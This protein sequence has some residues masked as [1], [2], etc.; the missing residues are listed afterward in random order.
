LLIIG[1]K[2]TV[3]NTMKQT[4]FERAAID[5]L[6]KRWYDAFDEMYSKIADTCATKLFIENETNTKGTSIIRGF[7]T[8]LFE[9]GFVKWENEDE[10]D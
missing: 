10:T 5:I 2:G 3:K 6:G 9:Y 4:D 7:L 1:L 8:E